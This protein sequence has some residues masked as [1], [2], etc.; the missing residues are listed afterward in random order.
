MALSLVSASSQYLDRAAAILSAM[1][2]SFAC[3]YK[4]TNNTGQQSCISICKNSST[5]A[6][7][8]LSTNAGPAQARGEQGGGG[9]SALS[10]GSLTVGGWNHLLAVFTSSTSRDIYLNGVGPVNNAVAEA[11]TGLVVTAIGA[12]FNASATASLF[13]NGVVAYP[14]IWNLALNSTD[15]TNLYNGGSGQDPYKIQTAGIV[16]LSMLSEL[17][18]P[19]VDMIT[20]VSWTDHGTPTH[21]ADPF[22]INRFKGT[23]AGLSTSTGNL[24]VGSGAVFA[25]TLAGSS[26]STGTLTVTKPLAGTLAGHSTST[27]TLAATKPLAGT[28]AG[29]AAHTGALTVPSVIHFLGVLAGLPHH[30]GILTV[31]TPGVITALS[32]S[33][34]DVSAAVALAVAGNTVVIPAGSCVWAA[35]LVVSPT[36]AII[37]SGTKLARAPGFLGPFFCGTDWN[38]PLFTVAGIRFS[39]DLCGRRAQRVAGTAICYH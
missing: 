26:T 13:A 8:W 38:V 25:G 12:L 4:P 34:A 23:L 10:V 15:D 6:Y 37:G 33:Y 36:I 16:S 32:C 1:P 19:W 21:A 9:G 30:T 24:T 18:T 11:T 28:L 35:T 20:G 17:S 22:T 29:H 3:W 14:T 5:A 27:G 39:L 2:L 31:T 7:W